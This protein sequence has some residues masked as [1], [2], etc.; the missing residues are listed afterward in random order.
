MVKKKPSERTKREAIG[1]ILRTLVGMWGSKAISRRKKL[2]IL[3]VMAK[4]FL[5]ITRRVRC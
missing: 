4:A 1:K 5:E 3:R 2:E